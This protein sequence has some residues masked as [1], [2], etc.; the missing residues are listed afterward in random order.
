[1]FG[2]MLHTGAKNEFLRLFAAAFTA[3]IVA[4]KLGCVNAIER[5]DY[6]EEFNL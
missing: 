6:G 4:V 2:D 3:A 5:R 1:M